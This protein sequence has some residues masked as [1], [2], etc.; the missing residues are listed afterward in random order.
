L[1]LT[2]GVRGFVP[3]M[4]ALHRGHFALMEQCAKECSTP[5][6]SIFVNPKQFG[7]TEDFS[8]YPR[9]LEADLELCKRAG[10]KVVFTPDSE[11]IY[12]NA[13]TTIHVEGVSELYE[14][15]IRPGHFDGVATVV[16]ALFNIV[17]PNVA[18]F[19]WKDVQQCAVISNMVEALHLPV[20]LQF[21]ETVRESD[22]L[23]LS[24]RNRYLSAE[25]RKLAP[26][27]FRTM[28]ELAKQILHQPNLGRELM[29][30]YCAEKR[31]ALTNSGFEVDYLDVIDPATMRPSRFTANSRIIVAAKIGSTRLIDNIPIQS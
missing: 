27:L 4:G 5:V 11:T 9:T 21:C 16:N 26:T 17:Q 22:G 20:R 19:G 24:S 3:T 10:C 13:T 15:A 8:R 30:E 18:Y 31:D 2:G 6:V 29:D 12:G 23:A 28:T 25:N 1:G 14:G 7:P